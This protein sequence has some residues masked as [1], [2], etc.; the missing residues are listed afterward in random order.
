MRKKMKEVKI[1][2]GTFLKCGQVHERDGRADKI[3]LIKLETLIHS[4]TGDNG[5]RE[6]ATLRDIKLTLLSEKSFHSND[7]MFRWSFGI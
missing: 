1:H 2:A 4:H 5:Q 7:V 6:L 3:T